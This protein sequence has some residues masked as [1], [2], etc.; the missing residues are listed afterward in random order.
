L[1]KKEK[2][3]W[4]AR[5]IPELLLKR[6]AGDVTIPATSTVHAVLNTGID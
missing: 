3:H 5:K 1:K 4:G 2:P 6:L